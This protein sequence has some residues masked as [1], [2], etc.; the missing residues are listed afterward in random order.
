MK[1]CDVREENVL[2]TPALSG[3]VSISESPRR[4]V[5]LTSAINYCISTKKKKH[6]KKIF[7]YFHPQSRRVHLT[8]PFQLYKTFF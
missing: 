8:F 3:R 7:L 2:V 1:I 6:L 5:K 4:C